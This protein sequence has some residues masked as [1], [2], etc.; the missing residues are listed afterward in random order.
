MVTQ[1]AKLPW[2]V[3]GMPSCSSL[4]EWG[5]VN[6]WFAGSGGMLGVRN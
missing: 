6:G 4:K 2:P 3:M 5:R 1:S